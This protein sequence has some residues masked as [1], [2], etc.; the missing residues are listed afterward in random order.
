MYD[1]KHYL[2]SV[3]TQKTRIPKAPVN[4]TGIFIEMKIKWAMPRSTCA[5]DNWPILEV[6]SDIKFQAY[7][8]AIDTIKRIVR[9]LRG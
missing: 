6:R 8:S 9:I 3:Q 7:E 5:V 4:G 2:S 1:K